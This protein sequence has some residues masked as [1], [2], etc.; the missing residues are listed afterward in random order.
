MNHDT[1]ECVLPALTA[2][3]LRSS[4]CLLDN[5]F[6]TLWTQLGMKRLLERCGFHK[7]S[8]VCVDAVMYA[9]TM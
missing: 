3:F 1:S 6:A 7:R 2:D 4:S 5:V 9:L 8:G